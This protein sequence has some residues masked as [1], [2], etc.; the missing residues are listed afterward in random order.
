MISSPQDVYGYFEVHYLA[1]DSLH[2][3]CLG[4]RVGASAQD[5]S[6]TAVEF[7]SEKLWS[8]LFLSVEARRMPSNDHCCVPDCHNRRRKCPSLSFHTFP[9][10]QDFRKRWVIAI[11]RDEGPSFRITSNTVVCSAH[12][13]PS[14]YHPFVG[15]AEKVQSRKPCR[16][17]KNDAVPSVFSFRPASARRPSPGDRIAERTNRHEAVKRAAAAVFYGPLDEKSHLRAVVT[18]KDATLDQLRTELEKAKAEIS[19]LKTQVLR[20]ANVANDQHMKFLTGLSRPYWD[21]LWKDLQPSRETVLS[22]KVAATEAAGRLSSPGQGRKCALTLEDELLLTLMRLRLGRLERSLAYEFGIDKSTVSRI[23][24]KWINYLYLRLGDLPIWPE[25]EAVEETMPQ[26]FKECYPNTF[27]IIDA[28]EIRCEIPSSLPLQSQFFSSYKNH[29]TKKGLVAIAPSG[30]FS[31]IGELYC[32]A[33]SDRELTMKSGFL[34]L[35]ESVPKGKSIM[36]DRGFDIQD[37]LA[38]YNVLMNIPAFRFS[39]TSHLSERDVISTQKI[40]R[41]RIHVERAIGQVKH[42]FHIFD[43]VLPLSLTG[44]INQI[45]TVCCLLANFSG[46]LI[47]DDIAD[48]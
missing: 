30:A 41:V 6:H 38:K 7:C 28:T 40:A 2:N 15:V 48:A 35:L 32:G 21:A 16:F 29:T 25:W 26:C 9:A 31:F 27:A 11:R 8:S 10:N 42:R 3:Y 46:P 44:S 18:E 14:D 45:W 37:L 19:S 20:F 43:A 23:F 24:T 13:R 4:S 1:I 47:A 17:L 22:Q 36:A 5:P 39:A 12:F 33:V 34:D